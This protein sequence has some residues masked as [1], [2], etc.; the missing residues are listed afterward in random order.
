MGTGQGYFLPFRVSCEVKFTE[1]ESSRLEALDFAS[2]SL[3]QTGV[4]EPWDRQ[5]LG[6][7]VAPSS[8]GYICLC[9][10]SV[11]MG[12]LHIHLLMAITLSYL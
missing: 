6:F 2:L 12:S 3:F 7:V 1:S 8:P 10:M 5:T 11:C 9:A 4:P